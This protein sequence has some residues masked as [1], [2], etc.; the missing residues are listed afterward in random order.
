MRNNTNS[1]LHP[2]SDFKATMEQQCNNDCNSIEAAMYNIYEST[3]KSVE[4][5]LQE[6]SSVL[7]RIGNF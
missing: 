7:E 3:N 5:K 1:R 6:L 4:E 2:F